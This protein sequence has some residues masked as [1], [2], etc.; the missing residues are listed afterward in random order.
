MLKELIQL[1]CEL[2]AFEIVDPA[3]PFLMCLR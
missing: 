2:G 3:S 1:K